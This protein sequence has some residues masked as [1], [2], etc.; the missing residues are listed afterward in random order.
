MIRTV[1]FITAKPGRREEVLALFHANA[2]IVLKEKGCIEYEA[3][4]DADGIGPFQTKLGPDSFIIL[5]TWE[6]PEALAAHVVAPHMVTY[7]A[8]TKDLYAS[9]AIHVLNPAK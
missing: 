1:V 7:G 6:S 9:R 5:E 4:V 8:K 3:H 2:P